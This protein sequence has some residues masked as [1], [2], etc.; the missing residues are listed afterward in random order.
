MPFEKHAKGMFGRPII[1]DSVRITISPKTKTMTIAANLYLDFFA[2]YAYAEL[3]WNDETKQ[4]GVSTSKDT[5][6][7]LTFA[8]NSKTKSA[9]MACSAF[10]KKHNLAKGTYPAEF[11]EDEGLLIFKPNL[12]GEG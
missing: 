1:H 11:D 2:P 8:A 7:K 9:R 5:G 10:I 3:Y 6:Y 4:V 12:V